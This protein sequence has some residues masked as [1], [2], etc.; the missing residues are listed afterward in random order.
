MV[1]ALAALHRAG[2][3]HR[4]VQ[5]HSFSYLT[6]PT[7]DLL[8]NRLLITDMSLC[9]YDVRSHAQMCPI[10]PN[11]NDCRSVMRVR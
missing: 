2:F 5:P 10:A 7:L 8:T 6:P 4:L 9:E 1:R 3:A 11:K